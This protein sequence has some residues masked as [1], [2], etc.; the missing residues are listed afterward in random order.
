MKKIVAALCLMIFGAPVV[1]LGLAGMGG[2]EPIYDGRSYVYG[3]DPKA[4]AWV[5]HDLKELMKAGRPF[6]E[7][8]VGE[9]TSIRKE[10]NGDIVVERYGDGGDHEVWKET[11][12]GRWERWD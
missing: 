8:R 7:S 9:P 11:S 1:A 5:Q 12:P 3:W 4:K 2:G 10:I 6:E